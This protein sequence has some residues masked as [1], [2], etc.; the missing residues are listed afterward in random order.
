ML[1]FLNIN[2]LAVID[3]LQ[4]EFRGGLNVLSGET[5][6]GKSIIIDALGLL[7]GDRASADMVR[8]G[9]DRAFVEGVFGITGNLPL[10]DLLSESGMEIDQED[11]IIRRELSVGGKGRIFVNN[12][13]ANLGLLK[14]V[15]PHLIDLHG[16]GD[17]QSLL[18]PE[19]H[20]NLLDAFS[21]ADQNRQRIFQGYD[22]LLKVVRELEE[23]RKSESERL[24]SL[25]IIEFQINELEQ[26]KLASNEDKEL[27]AERKLLANVEKLATLC[28]EAYR[29]VYEDELSVL[30]RLGTVQRRA[31][32]RR[33]ARATLERA[34]AAFASLPAPG[35]AAKA[36]T[37][38]ARIGGRAP[39]RGELT[40]AE[41]RIAAL[42]AEGMSNR[43]VAAALFLTEHTVETALTRIYRK[44][45]LRS[46]TA[47]ARR[48]ASKS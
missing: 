29:F 32:Q 47:L 3:S 48:L 45:G 39:P 41:Q 27:E 28:N 46:R 18:S 24:Q 15:Q 2:N 11:L 31:K 12:R 5:G 42:V 44:L 25:D 21:G 34:L 30:T 20:L 36:H 22:S 1:R 14:S 19:A 43:E 7:L 8:T 10:I 35:W 33:A 16:Q 26:A 13:L 38:L 6:S 4:I 40:E 23:A 17:Q 37:E 9:S